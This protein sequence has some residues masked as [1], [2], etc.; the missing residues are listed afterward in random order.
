MSK[1]CECS[2]PLLEAAG[3]PKCDVHPDMH[4]F[5]R[6]IPAIRRS[7]TVQHHD[8]TLLNDPDPR[9]IHVGAAD[10]WLGGR[11]M[12]QTP[13]SPLSH[14]VWHRKDVRPGEVLC[15]FER[16]QIL[17]KNTQS[18]GSKSVFFTL[19]CTITPGKHDTRNHLFPSRFIFET[20]HC[21]L[22]WHAPKW[23]SW[24]T[25]CYEFVDS[26]LIVAVM[27]YGLMSKGGAMTVSGADERWEPLIWLC[28]RGTSYTISFPTLVQ[29]AHRVWRED[30]EAWE[31]AL[32]AQVIGVL[33]PTR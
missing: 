16:E 1:Y 11:G 2:D 8:A 10:R 25:S 30:D 26:A 23:A 3:L 19:Y 31:S 20:Y 12:D 32:R 27:I 33:L 15:C 29:L 9:T 13:I 22:D 5:P 14:A 18:G 21:G 4:F 7:V 24:P 28:T 17:L 6:R